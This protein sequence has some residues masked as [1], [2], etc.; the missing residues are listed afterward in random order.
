[1]RFYL[2]L[3]CYRV[4]T[5]TVAFRGISYIVVTFTKPN[6]ARSVALYVILNLLLYSFASLIRHNF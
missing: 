2:V 1:M 4:A 3:R 6:M 5:F